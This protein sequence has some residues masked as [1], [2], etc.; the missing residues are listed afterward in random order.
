MKA[1]TVFK[2]SAL[3]A[4]LTLGVAHAAE[5]SGS[6]LSGDEI[7]A[8]AGADA[9]LGSYSV[10]VHFDVHMHRPLSLRSGVDAIAYYKAPARAALKITNIPG[11]L[12]QF[13]KDSY[14]IDMI[15]QT[16]PSK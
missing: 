12:R 4:S 5:P 8:R 3:V 13:F 15:P 16:W 9:G 1:T 10:P 6:S 2:T 7:L 11:P 14:T